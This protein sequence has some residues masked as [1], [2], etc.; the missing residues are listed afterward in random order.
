[1]KQRMPKA[2]RNAV[3]TPS[4]RQ[5]LEAFL[6]GLAFAIVCGIVVGLLM[7]LVSH[8]GLRLMILCIAA[9]LIGYTRT[10]VMA[11]HGRTRARPRRTTAL[12]DEQPPTLDVD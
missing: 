8:E 7:K 1:M 11:A 2:L 9:F 4:F 5:K 10:R 6:V 3:E 12:D